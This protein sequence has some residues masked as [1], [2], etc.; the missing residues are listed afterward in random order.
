LETGDGIGETKKIV[1]DYER[2]ARDL[3]VEP[4]HLLKMIEAE[5]AKEVEAYAR[6]RAKLA[7]PICKRRAIT[8]EDEA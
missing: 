7:R 1:H 4:W 3:G 6:V 2:T 5:Q 8:Q